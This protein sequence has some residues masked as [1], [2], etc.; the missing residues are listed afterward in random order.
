MQ[1]RNPTFCTLPDIRISTVF[2]KSTELF[3]TPLDGCLLK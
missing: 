2:T 3:P 1:F